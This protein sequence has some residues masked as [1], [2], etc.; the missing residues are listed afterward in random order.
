MLC[1]LCKSDNVD[2]HYEENHQSGERVVMFRC[3]V[4]GARQ[5]AFHVQPRTGPDPYRDFDLMPVQIYNLLREEGSKSAEEI[6][7][8]FGSAIAIIEMQ[9]VN[10]L[11]MGF[12]TMETPGVFTA[13]QGAP[14]S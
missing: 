9:L 12:L 4:C 8:F 3:N 1:H 5:Y 13:V 10:L 7:H 11:N 2:Q 6:A 14:Q